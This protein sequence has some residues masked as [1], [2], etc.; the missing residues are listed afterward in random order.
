MGFWLILGWGAKIFGGNLQE[1]NDRR[2]TSFGKKLWRCSKYHSLYARQ[3][4]RKKTECLRR[5]GYISPLCSAYLLIPLLVH[6]G[7]DGRRNHSCTISAQS[8]QGLGSYGI[9]NISL[10]HMHAVALTTVCTSVLYCGNGNQQV[11]PMSNGEFYLIQNRKAWT[12]C[13]KI[14]HNWLRPR[15]D[16]AN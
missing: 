10:F 5:E 4:N 2:S 8:V 6:V 15:G 3:R 12:D 1:C 9:S 7:S 11:K 13:N 16:S 14:W